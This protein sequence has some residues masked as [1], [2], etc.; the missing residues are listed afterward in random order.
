LSLGN[1]EIARRF[2]GP[3]QS[4]NGGYVAGRLA[5]WVQ[6]DDETP[7]IAAR[8]FSP[9]PLETPL[10]VRD[11]EGRFGL[12]V[13]ETRVAEAR[14]VALDL[15]PPDAPSF[16]EA[17]RAAESFRGFADPIFPTC[18][19]CGYEREGGDG[20]R[21]FPGES[22]HPGVFAAPWIPDA[23]LASEGS[24]LVATEFLW[25]ALDCPGAFAFPQPEGKVVLLGEMQVQ[26]T[27][28]VRVGESCVLASWFIEQS[29]RKYFT[30]SALYNAA[31]DCCGV[32]M[33]IWIAIEPDAVPRS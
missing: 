17:R 5:A 1:I 27:G 20:L 21:I 29:G 22:A 10:E 7:A 4:G 11:N 26:L 31:G 12:F 32:A 14:A 23:S 15:S 19:V 24:D 33:G 3:P 6:T 8:L 25:A 18:F 9:P 28:D 16:E 30:G 13:E 2:C